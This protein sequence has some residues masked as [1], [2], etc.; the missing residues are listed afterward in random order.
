VW[1]RLTEL[2]SNP[3]RLTVGILGHVILT[4]GYVFAFDAS[5]AAFGFNL[6]LLDAAIVYLIGNTLGALAP[7]PGGMELGAGEAVKVT[8][9]FSAERVERKARTGRN[10]RTGEEIEIPAGFGVKI[11]AGSLLKKAVAK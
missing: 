11:S 2:L 7:T 1:P 8:G 6:T 4:L 5:L 9:L 10:P 3:W